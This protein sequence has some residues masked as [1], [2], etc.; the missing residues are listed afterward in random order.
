[1]TKVEFSLIQALAATLSFKFARVGDTTV[2]GC[3]AFLPNGF[4]VGYGESACVDPNNFDFE[5]GKKY[6][7]ERCVLAATNKLWE[8]EGYLL[9]VTG[10]TSD[11]FVKSVG[12][13]ANSCTSGFVSIENVMQ[14]YKSHKVVSAAKIISVANKC[15]IDGALS[16]IIAD[17]EN[18]E[19]HLPYLAHS[20]LIARY[21]PQV[22]DY[23]VMYSGDYIAISPKEAFECGYLLIEDI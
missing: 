10:A 3:W 16:L 13:V 8:L 7:Q 4:K 19:L 9:K 15:E 11:C 22:G 23:V 14:Q 20:D 2:T 6:A 21:A 12:E 1:M 5:L 18:E 17:P